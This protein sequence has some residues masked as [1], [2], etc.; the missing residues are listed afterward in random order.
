L[1]CVLFFLHHSSAPYEIISPSSELSSLA[2]I[3]APLFLFPR[4][5]PL[6]ALCGTCAGFLFFPA[7]HFLQDSSL[8][9][10]NRKSSLIFFSF[11]CLLLWFPVIVNLFHYRPVGFCPLSRPK[12]SFS[13]LFGATIPA[14]NHLVSR[15][16][17]FPLSIFIRNLLFFFVRQS[18]FIRFFPSLHSF[19]SILFSL[20]PF[21]PFSAR[22]FSSWLFLGQTQD[23]IT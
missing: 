9:F 23:L 19:H 3:T 4:Q 14:E 6:F 10:G 8:T 15:A 2:C 17:P 12:L 1:I 20:V 18:S 13:P 22:L 7:S 16:A 11:V 5:P 21:S